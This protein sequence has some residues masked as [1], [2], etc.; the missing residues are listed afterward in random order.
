M[1]P[2]AA[3]IGRTQKQYRFQV[4][5]KALRHIP[6]P[7]LRQM[8]EDATTRTGSLPREYRMAVDV[9]AMSL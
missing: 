7:V 9:D 8:I 4:I 3:F 1:G 6:M 5:L 2:Q